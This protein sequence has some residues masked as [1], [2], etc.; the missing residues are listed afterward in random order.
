MT[1]PDMMILIVFLLVVLVIEAVFVCAIAGAL[2]GDDE[3]EG[4]E[5]K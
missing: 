1:D 3:Q 2:K 5:S 4:K